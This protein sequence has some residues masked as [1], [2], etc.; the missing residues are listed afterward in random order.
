LVVGYKLFGQTGQA[1]VAD[2]GKVELSRE[3]LWMS[4]SLSL[5]LCVSVYFAD[6]CVN[7]HRRPQKQ[8]ATRRL[9]PVGNA[10]FTSSKG[11]QLW[12]GGTSKVKVS[13]GGSTKTIAN[14]SVD[15]R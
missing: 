15:E 13:V 7:T 2:I 9:N 6:V 12:R 14:S 1:N 3:G 11:I 10:G 8:R 5:F 4:L